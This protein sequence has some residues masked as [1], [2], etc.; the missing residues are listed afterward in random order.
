MIQGAIRLTMLAGGLLVTSACTTASFAPPHVDVTGAQTVKARGSCARVASG[1]GAIA[2]DIAGATELND[3][4][5]AAYRC[6]RD[7]AADGRQ[8]FEV[9]SFLA[10]IA[11]ALGPTYGLTE[12]GRIAAL[13]S[14][15]VLGKAN[16]YYA[17]KEKARYL[18]AALDA[19]LCIKTQSVGV[20]FFDTTRGP[21]VLALTGVAGDPKGLEAEFDQIRDRLTELGAQEKRWKQQLASADKAMSAFDGN[22]PDHA[23][24]VR[25]ANAASAA[26]K[27][28]ANQAGPLLKRA[29]EI[30]N[31]LQSGG[32]VGATAQQSLMLNRPLPNGGG[33]VVDVKQ[34]Y[35]EMVSAALLSVERVL[36]Q[37][38]RDV[39]AFDAEGITA[40]LEQV[41]IAKNKT[42]PQLDALLAK[43]AGAHALTADE[44]ASKVELE[45]EA[46]QPSLQACVIRAKLTG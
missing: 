6:A 7:E 2:R 22:S 9:P 12:G 39:G 3:R 32:S 35:F 25:T 5:V 36:S 8:V 21:A 44:Q 28:I 34:Q 40:Q 31:L 42:K 11:G 20:S 33:I 4:F 15:A 43:G 17:P 46:L 19:V 27:E 10:L 37:R 38:F 26:L 41:I 16:G 1:G 45:I 30:G 23:E 14:A 18:D 13:S 24:A 29:N